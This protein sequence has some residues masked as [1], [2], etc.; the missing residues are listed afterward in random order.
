MGSFIA[1]HP[2]P[3]LKNPKKRMPVF[4]V[5]NPRNLKSPYTRK[6]GHTI[7]F[8]SPINPAHTLADVVQ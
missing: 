4:P 2:P 1:Y 3:I 5:H 7:A 8:I 6:A